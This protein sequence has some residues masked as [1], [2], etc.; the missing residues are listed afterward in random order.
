MLYQVTFREVP[1]EDA[2]APL[3]L[4]A[5]MEEKLAKPPKARK[6]KLSLSENIKSLLLYSAIAGGATAVNQGDFWIE[7]NYGD[8]ANWEATAHCD[9]NGP[10]IGKRVEDV[11]S[12]SYHFTND[13]N[14]KAAPSTDLVLTGTPR[15]AFLKCNE[16]LNRRGFELWNLEVNFS[17]SIHNVVG[18][19]GKKGS[20][21]S[22]SFSQLGLGDDKAAK[23]LLDR[24]GRESLNLSQL[25]NGIAFSNDWYLKKQLDIKQWK[26]D[27]QKAASEAVLQARTTIADWIRPASPS[28]P[29]TGS[30]ISSGPQVR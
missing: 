30:E 18:M 22:S 25:W 24:M 3:E 21:V 5:A 14:Y 1:K 17:K 8:R 28:R 10:L 13:K 11:Q 12:L 27:H 16:V 6:P 15:E 7:Q 23:D 29:E 2:R 20:P 26:S 19:N 4:T 9:I